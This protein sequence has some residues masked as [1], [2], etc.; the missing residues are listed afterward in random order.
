MEYL[1]HPVT[2]L[3]SD[4]VQITSS[5][6]FTRQLLPSEYLLPKSLSDSQ[7]PRKLK[8]NSLF[9]HQGTTARATLPTDYKPTAEYGHQ[10]PTGAMNLTSLPTTLDRPQ[11][12]SQRN[13]ISSQPVET[14]S[15]RRNRQPRPPPTS[16]PINPTP[17][18]SNRLKEST[19]PPLA[20][21]HA[22]PNLQPSAQPVPSPVLNN[23]AAT[24]F[25]NR[26]SWFQSSPGSKELV[27]V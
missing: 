20:P 17:A 10:L 9:T 21:P 23:R 13:A 7:F 27:F 2:Q 26:T 6:R 25:D 11:R 12:S 5:Y 14:G 22:P 8:L 16:T 18:P 1:C 19:P 15:L 24:N 4:G 3:P